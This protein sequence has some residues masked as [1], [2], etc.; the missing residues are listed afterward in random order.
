M[1]RHRRS[2]VPNAWETKTTDISLGAALE[3]IHRGRW[4][5]PVASIRKKYAEAL[6][7][8]EKDGNSDPHQAAKDAINPLK[9][10]LHGVTFSGRFKV[11]H[12]DRL[13]AHS[14]YL[15]ADI[16]KVPPDGCSQIIEALKND[17][18][19]QAAF[20][21][22]SGWGV[23]VVFLILPDASKHASSYLAVERHVRQPTAKLLIP[24]ARIASGLALCRTILTSS[25]D[26]TRRRFFTP[27]SLNCSQAFLLLRMGKAGVQPFYKRNEMEEQAHGNLGIWTAGISDCMVVC[28]A[29]YSKGAWQQFWF[30]HVQGGQYAG[31]V[32]A[33]K[34]ELDDCPDKD[35]RCAV[36][37]A[38][39]DPGFDTILKAL[40]GI[41]F[42]E[43][44][45]KIYVSD[46]GNRGFAFGLNFLDDVFGEVTLQG[47]ALPDDPDK[48]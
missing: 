39:Y 3:N 38:G 1:A 48:M 7:Q 31:I 45:L 21:S 26:R 6:A 43:E 44:N 27:L 23:K 15:C 32:E 41:G 20:R 46:T 19:V 36:V 9:R 14:G 8:A 18:H 17:P 33:I 34:T 30:Q 47:E 16:D 2:I 24:L 37:A 5:E 35:Q 4:A 28:A 25:S 29:Y 13:D 12:G 10:K 42:P 11:R 22:P 40:I